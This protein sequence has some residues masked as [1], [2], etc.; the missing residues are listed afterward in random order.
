MPKITACGE[1]FE[2]AR[3]EKGPDS[4]LLYDEA[5]TNTVFFGGI[6]NWDGYEID[7]VPITELPEN[8]GNNE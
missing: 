3:Y 1:N 2:C 8:G 7:G 6:L 5:G 4:L